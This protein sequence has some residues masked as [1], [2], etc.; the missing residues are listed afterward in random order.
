MVPAISGVISEHR[1]IV[2]TVGCDLNI[3]PQN[4]VCL[5]NADVE[6]VNDILRVLIVYAWGEFIITITP[7]KLK[8]CSDK[9]QQKLLQVGRGGNKTPR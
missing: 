4:L 5:K 9:L 3:S 8:L 1:L 2:S 6:P 7:R